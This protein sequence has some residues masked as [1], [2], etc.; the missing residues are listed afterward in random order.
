MSVGGGIQKRNA[1]REYFG[2][3]SYVWMCMLYVRNKKSGGR[4]AR[5]NVWWRLLARGRVNRYRQI[6]GE[7]MKSVAVTTVVKHKG[8]LSY[9]EFQRQH[10][11]R[12]LPI[13][14]YFVRYKHTTAIRMH[15]PEGKRIRKG[16]LVRR[17]RTEGDPSMIPT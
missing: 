13:I 8:C 14:G 5:D 10:F 2:D 1:R 3:R 7:F 4:C 17:Q 6:D 16:D 9:F 12:R 11:P 15:N